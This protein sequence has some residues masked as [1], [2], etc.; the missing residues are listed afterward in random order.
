MIG[1]ASRCYVSAYD[2][3]VIH[4][5]RVYPL[6]KRSLIAN[7]NGAIEPARTIVSAQWDIDAPYAVTMSDAAISA[8]QRETSV[9]INC[10]WC[11]DNVVRVVVTLDDGAQ[12][13]QLFY[14]RCLWVAW[15]GDT[16]PTSGP[17]RL[18]VT[19]P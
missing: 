18:V 11:G 3:E 14:V 1:R 2:R 10:G 17:T 15:F 6:E 16:S 13:S 8:N 19:A 9:T 12:L 5:T 7:F 4:Q